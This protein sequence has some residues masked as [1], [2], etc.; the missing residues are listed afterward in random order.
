MVFLYACTIF[1]S[2]FLLFQVQPMIGKMILPWFGGSAAVWS[3]CMLFFQVVL[4]LGYLY[5]HLTTSYLS[6]RRQSLLHLALLLASLLLLPVSLGERWKP[7]PG[8]DPTL[9]IAGL[10]AASIGL[11]YFLLSSTGPLVQAWFAREKAGSLPYRLFAL[12]NLGS[13]L[14]LL[15][16]PLLF[17]P[18]LSV[19]AMAGAWSWA[20]AGF[21]LV[22]GLLTARQLRGGAAPAPDAVA[23]E[24]L[25]RYSH[26]WWLVLAAL[27]SV[28]LMSVTSHLTQNIAPIPLLWVLPLA[29]YLAS[30]ILCFEGGGWYRRRWYLPLFIVAVPAML[31]FS[32]VPMLLSYHLT[33]A[34]TLYCAGLFVCCMVCHG[35]LA[36]IRPHASR[37]TSYY[38][39]L[40]AGGAA[41]GAFVALLAPRLF[42][43]DYEMSIALVACVIAI[44]MLIY[45]EA[46][47]STRPWLQ[48]ASWHKAVVFGVT[49]LVVL[50]GA[51]ML[52]LDQHDSKQRNFYGIVKI[53]DRETDGQRYRQLAHGTIVHGVQHLAP[54]RR[55]WPT[56]YY[57]AESG[58]GMALYSVIGA[59][60]VRVGVVGLGTGTM[61]AYC[62]P[63]DHYRF[64]EINPHVVQAAYK[65]FSFLSD[66]P[67]TVAIAEGDARLSLEREAPQQF[68]LLVLDAFT[69][70]A[71]PVHLLTREAFAVYFRHL[72]PG[73]VL[74][75]HTSNL[76]LDLVPVVQ[77]AAK[78]HGKEALLFDRAG[79][80]TKRTNRSTWVLLAAPSAAA[81]VQL[82][83]TGTPATAPVT[84][85]PWTDDYSSIFS[86]LK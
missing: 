49:F 40:A 65:S 68:D 25:P 43:D 2:A 13:M 39:M 47:S 8:D 56:S 54:E 10:L 72:K 58:V 1:L 4:F 41:G 7:D 9:M 11:S 69:G 35:E 63:G 61:A 5:T 71:I 27:P 59:G 44:P 12:S 66:C 32:A 17:E 18:R 24:A 77:L 74:A 70:D 33:V 14:G 31:L 51:R 57:G 20:Y 67:G 45:R 75:V 81:A 73:S 36:N 60:P 52:F 85:R 30:F 50:V 28:L 6:Q 29:L 23:V 55:R 62:R 76:H 38:L 53:K 64:Y 16:Y 26:R 22:C 84:L 37:L 86:V 46:D 83:Q 82:R 15:S 34:V 21:V 80:K 78:Y 3:T 48:K 79:D 19:H 42:N